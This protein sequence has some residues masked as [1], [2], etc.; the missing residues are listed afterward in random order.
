L[1]QVRVF[2]LPHYDELNRARGE[3]VTRLLAEL[4]DP[5]QLHTA[6]DVGCGVGYFSGL[7][8]S[9]GL[10][11]TG[12]DGRKGNAEEAARRVPGVTF[13][14]VNVEDSEFCSLGTFDLVF[15]FGLLYHLESPFRAIRNL[16]ALT[17]KVLAVE[18][19]CA[20]GSTVSMELLDE[21]GWED[22]GLNHVAFYPTEPCLVK[23]L[24]RAGFPFVYGLATPPDHADFR[25]S[26][27]RRKARTMLM[28]SKQELKTRALILLKEPMRVQDIWIVPPEFSGPR[29]GRMADLVRRRMA[30]LAL[31]NPRNSEG[32]G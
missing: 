21:S 31:R 11:V 5:L 12:V 22:Q 25:E 10:A 15:C 4:K 1:G 27:L 18:S 17:G 7:L 23:M 32:D 19:M 30:R 14:T 2:D 29:F 6:M 13:H 8:Q 20:P 26:Q 9:L 28:V 24:Y 16:H 3:V